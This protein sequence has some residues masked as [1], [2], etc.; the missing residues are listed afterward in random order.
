VADSQGDTAEEAD[1]VEAEVPLVAVAQADSY[2]LLLIQ[3]I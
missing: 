1:L 2:N 3:W